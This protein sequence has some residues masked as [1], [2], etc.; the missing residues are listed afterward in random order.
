M[1]LMLLICTKLEG[2][3]KLLSDLGIQVTQYIKVNYHM[4]S[5]KAKKEMS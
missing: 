3:K 2:V 1:R 5:L 4:V